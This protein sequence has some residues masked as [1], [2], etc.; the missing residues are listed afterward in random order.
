MTSRTPLTADRQVSALR[1]GDKPYEVSVAGARGLAL[2]VFPAGTK[3]FEFR[4]VALNGRRRRLPLGNYPGLSLADAREEAGGLQVAVTRGGDP[5]AERAAARVAA[6]TG[7]T[8]TELAEAYFTAA[9]KGLH[10]GRGRPKRALTIKVERNRFD[11]HIAPALGARRFNEIKRADI[12]AFM[13]DRAASAGLA[14][15][16]VASIGGTLSAILAFAVYEERIEANPAS[17][18]TR[19]L[20]LRSRDRTFD[21]NTIKALWAALEGVSTLPAP[22]RLPKA[23]RPLV[24]PP[25]P[26]RAS[27]DLVVALSLRFALLTLA[28][29]NDVASA[30]WGEIDLTKA[31]WTIPASR[32]KGG[33]IH[34]IPLSP[35]AVAVL[36]EA[37]DLPGSGGEVIF[38]SPSNPNPTAEKPPKSITP[39]A[40]TRALTRTLGDLSLPHG[41]PH[42]FRRAGATTLT[43]ERFG[44]RR[45]T[46]GLVLGHSIHDGAAVTAVYDRND[47]LADKRNAL[48]LW[49][50]HITSPPKADDDDNEDSNVLKFTPAAGA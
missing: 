45:F 42:D 36:K 2:R 31:T 6:R 9:A 11:R 37:R 3:S 12:K 16:T 48:Q 50:A 13:R 7:D 23:K 20:A 15:D 49:G 39:S 19:P 14:A 29:R 35:Q 4:Y 8:L 44:I 22:T 10:G 21:D 40:L 1:P 46:V 5:A 24:K 28:R 41:S 47:Y 17:G 38:P 25:G 18:L 34:V 27:A 30:R 32:F 26:A 33:R 43:G